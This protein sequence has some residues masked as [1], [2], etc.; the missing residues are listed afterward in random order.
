MP[1]YQ[2]WIDTGSIDIPAPEMDVSFQAK[3]AH[4]VVH[5]IEAA[6]GSAFATARR[7]D[8]GG[9]FALLNRDVTVTHRQKLAVVYVVYF[10]INDHV[11]GTI[12]SGDQI[13]LINRDRPIHHH[14]PHQ[15]VERSHPWARKQLANDVD[16]QHQ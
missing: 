4:Q 14:T 7:T 1:A 5:A 9:D 16:H 3:A 6:Q 12:V 11:T 8:K 2:H 13:A 15:L 10:A